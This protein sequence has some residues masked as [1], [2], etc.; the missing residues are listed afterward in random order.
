MAP[1]APASRTRS[2]A[3]YPR[4]AMSKPPLCT[5][6]ARM[7]A[8]VTIVLPCTQMR[9][10][11]PAPAWWNSTSG[12]DDRPRLPIFT[13]GWPRPLH[14]ASSSGTDR[15][16]AASHAYMP[17]TWPGI[18]ASGACPMARTNSSDAA[19]EW[20]G[21]TN[22]LAPPGAPTPEAT[23]TSWPG[24]S[25]ST[26]TRRMGLPRQASSPNV[27]SFSTRA[28]PLPPAE[29]SIPPMIACST[30]LW[31]SSTTSH[32]LRGQPQGRFVAGVDGDLVARVGMAQHADA[33]IPVQHRPEFFVG[34]CA[35][36]RDDRVSR[37]HGLVAVRVDGHQRCATRAGKHGVE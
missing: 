6:A 15:D 28:L 11:V 20:S 26:E 14:A 34:E 3:K 29:R 19:L 35:A 18:T 1:G 16:A 36:V 33:R 7:S 32:P 2:E 22:D 24:P 13:V 23:M 27:R 9:T 21:L 8:D 31:T 5:A 37:A 4:A 30:S 17:G 12:R 25:S 10:F